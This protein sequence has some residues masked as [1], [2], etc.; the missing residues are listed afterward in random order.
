MRKLLTTVFLL[1]FFATFA[2]DA[3]AEFIDVFPGD[4]YEDAID[5]VDT[6]GIV[7]GYSDLTFRSA[8]SITRDQF[9]KIIILAKFTQEEVDACTSLPFPDV[10]S[11]NVFWGYICLA[12]QEGIVNGYSDGLYKPLNFITIGEAT[13]IISGAFDLTEDGVVGEGDDIFQPFVEALEARNAIPTEILYIDQKIS[14]GQMVE[15]MYRVLEE[16]TSN[17]TKTYNGLKSYGDTF[18]IGDAYLTGMSVSLKN[19][20]EPSPLLSQVSL[21]DSCTF[22]GP[23]DIY[24]DGNQIDVTIHTIRETAALCLT[25]ITE[26]EHLV[27]LNL[28]GLEV[29][30]YTVNV[31]NLSLD[32]EVDIVEGEHI[33]SV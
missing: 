14:R 5:Y 31:N 15:I 19:L 8:S 11:T 24:R 13:K 16:I 7:S 2:N 23:V 29:G 27:D 4:L 18:T 20:P 30:T 28:A 3:N 32:V 9:T 22:V 10:S 6:N 25:V 33:V 21:S 1:S 26:V 12:K 17:T